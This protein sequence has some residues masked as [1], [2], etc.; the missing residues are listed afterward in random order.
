MNGRMMTDTIHAHADIA[1]PAGA[2]HLAVAEFIAG[3]QV[4]CLANLASADLAVAAAE[5]PED[6]EPDHPNTWAAGLVARIK[7]LNT[8]SVKR[9]TKTTEVLPTTFA[10]NL[11]DGNEAHRHRYPIDANRTPL[12][13]VLRGPESAAV[14]QELAA[15]IFDEFGIDLGNVSRVAITGIELVVQC[16]DGWDVPAFWNAV[17]VWVDAQ[18][19]HVVSAVVHR[20]QRRP[21]MHVIALAVK[22]GRLAG[23]WL[24]SGDNRASY[25]TGRLYNH[26]R[27]VLGVRVDRTDPLAKLALKAGK[28][29][30][31]AA[32]AARRDAK[33]ERLAAIGVTLGEGIEANPGEGIA[34]EVGEGIGPKAGEGIG[35]DESPHPDALP[36][37]RVTE[38]PSTTSPAT[39]VSA[40]TGADHDAENGHLRAELAEARQQAEANQQALATARAE[41]KAL[42]AEFRPFKV[43]PEQRV[44]AREVEKARRERER[45]DAILRG[46]SGLGWV[47]ATE[48]EPFAG[49]SLPIVTD[50]LHRLAATGKVEM[51]KSRSSVN[52]LRTVY[53]LADSSAPA[54]AVPAPTT[55]P[56]PLQMTALQRDRRHRMLRELDKRGEWVGAAELGRDV[57]GLGATATAH[58]MPSLLDAGLV[59]VRAGRNPS[60]LARREYRLSDAGR[61]LLLTLDA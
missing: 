41:I 14:A 1:T 25:Q 16:P 7:T 59:D 17:M 44:A 34:A 36:S 58:A 38:R 27:D 8:R 49:V 55:E 61:A 39:S 53:R 4:P 43:T 45:S 32:A 15:S 28:G 29:P 51:A 30:K 56:P 60:G 21:H 54:P 52:L 47:T 23:D 37:L 6:P 40:Q 35:A 31:T 50:L 5:E 26:L 57:E 12:N 20:D 10:H 18:Y 42:L 2:V 19:Q 22:D 11:R 13:T 24:T 33:L 48:V 46:L 9:A 3:L